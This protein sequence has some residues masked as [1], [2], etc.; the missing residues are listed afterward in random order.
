MLRWFIEDGT[1]C[2]RNDEGRVFCPPASVIYDLVIS[3]KTN[4]EYS[5]IYMT[6]SPK[7]HLEGI[8]F[9]K[10][11]ARVFFRLCLEED[12]RITCRVFVRRRGSVLEVTD[13]FRRGVDHMVAGGA[14]FYFSANV[15]DAHEMISE[16]GI[17]DLLNVSYASYLKLRNLQQMNTSVEIEDS[18]QIRVGEENAVV[19]VGLS[20]K[21]Y[22]Y[23]FVGFNWLKFIT[24]KDCGCIL[25]DEMGLGKTLQVIAL[26]V[27]RKKKNA[28]PSLVVAPVSLLE[29]WKREIEKFAPGLRP[30]INHGPCRTGN[31]RELLP[32]DV[33]VISYSGAVS[34][35]SMLGMIKWDIVIVDE[36]QNIR[37]PVAAR[38]IAIKSLPRRSAIAVSGTPFQNHVADIWSVS[39]F[40]L[41]GYMGTLAAFKQKYSD[42]IVGAAQIE[43]L[44]SPVMIRRLVKDVAKDLPEKVVISQPLRMTDVEANLY[45]NSRRDILKRSTIGMAKLVELVSLRMFCAHPTLYAKTTCSDPL[46]NCTKY[47]RL[48]EV[49][50]EIVSRRDKLIVFTSFVQ[51]AEMMRD[52]LAWRMGVP[53]WTVNG[54]TPAMERQGIVDR[55]SNVVGSAILVLNPQAAGTGLNITAANHVIHYNLEWNPALEDQA[56]AR[57]FRRGQTK[58]VFVYRFYYKDTVEEFVN[59]KIQDKR[60]MSA[61]AVVG[62]GGDMNSKEAYMQAL[63]YSPVQV[64]SNK[65]VVV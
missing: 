28:G 26:L 50:T 30:W 7:S 23:Q 44:L 32:Y 2:F 17:T 36:A 57:A 35:G 51:M 25:G 14:W 61:L 13:Q 43:P 11:G 20:A 39:D 45:E 62:G 40:I 53:V 29:N 65:D 1:I 8:A 59:D 37:N 21:L 52:D 46:K 6:E 56:S 58:T 64:D 12:E 15:L 5:G 47:A 16:S 22:P 54:A 38:T 3:E 41:P 19:P 27:D 34:D 24:D 49:V 33:V 9:S 18:V 60:D 48:C 10:I 31:Y 55:F 63:R 4:V 42:D